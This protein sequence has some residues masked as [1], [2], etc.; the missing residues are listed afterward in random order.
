MVKD[1]TPIDG[2]SSANSRLP[3]A[4]SAASNGNRVFALGGDGRGA[5]SRRQRDIAELHIGDLGGQDILSEAQLSL[6]R[7]T[8]TLEVTLEQLEAAM[9]EGKDV[10]LDQYGRLYG[11]L[12]RGLETLGLQRVARD[13][14]GH[15]WTLAEIAADLAAKRI[16]EAPQ[17]P[18]T[19]DEPSTSP[20]GLDGSPEAPESLQ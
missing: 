3:K 4:K 19:P 14:D 12:R 17:P 18:K 16:Q 8:A 15:E 5:W 10:D 6:A 20:K 9:S 2:P 13:V 1:S 11:H 7:R